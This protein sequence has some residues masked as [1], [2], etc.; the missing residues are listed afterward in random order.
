[1]GSA[2]AQNVRR[3]ARAALLMGVAVALS[4]GGIAA[5]RG[6]HAA[7]AARQ[8]STTA[9]GY[10]SLVNCTIRTLDPKRDTFTAT[11]TSLQTGKTSTYTVVWATKTTATSVP[12]MFYEHAF[13]TKGRP[14]ELKVG[15]IVDVEGLLTK[16]TISAT[17]ITI[18]PQR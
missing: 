3:A 9:S 5:A 1:M 4:L 16:S 7:S 13:P 14:A 15:V 18:S 11:A 10:S 2:D 12:T 17:D 8:A 6:A